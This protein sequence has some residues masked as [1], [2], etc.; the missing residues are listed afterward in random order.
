MLATGTMSRIFNPWHQHSQGMF[1]M[2]Y[3]YHAGSGDGMA[4]AWKVGAEMVNMEIGGIG[5]RRDRL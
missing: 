4:M 2:L 5:R 3:H 1:K